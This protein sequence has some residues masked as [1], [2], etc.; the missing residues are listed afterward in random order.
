MWY[1]MISYH[2]ISHHIISYHITSQHIISYHITSHHIT[3]YHITSQHIIL[4]HIISYS[5]L[6]LY[7]LRT[8]CA[9][10]LFVPFAVHPATK[11]RV[12]VSPLTHIRLTFN[13]C[14]VRMVSLSCYSFMDDYCF[15][16]D[17]YNRA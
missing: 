3:S 15:L 14:L 16:R 12:T 1:D 17:R 11:Y 8:V 5:L 6:P 7:S 13:S 4:Y 10:K 2:I 9:A